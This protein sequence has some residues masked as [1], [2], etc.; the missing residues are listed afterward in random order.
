[1]EPHREEKIYCEIAICNEEVA[2]AGKQGYPLPK[3]GRLKDWFLCHKQLNSHKKN[4]EDT[5]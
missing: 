5:S 2:D 3:Q 1:L 4:A